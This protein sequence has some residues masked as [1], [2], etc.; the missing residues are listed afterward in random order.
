MIVIAQEYMEKNISQIHDKEYI[1]VTNI[2][3]NSVL[4]KKYERAMAALAICAE[5]EFQWNQYY[6]NE[7]L[8]K[9]LLEIS[10]HIFTIKSKE[11]YEKEDTIVFYDGF[12]LDTRGLALIYIKALV[13]S[14]KKI[15]Y[16]TLDTA[17]GKQPVLK[18]LFNGKNIIWEYIPTNFTYVKSARTLYEVINNY[19]PKAAFLYTTPYD[20]IGLSVFNYLKNRT[21]RYQINLTDH[22]FWLG[23][24]AFDYCIEFRTYGANISS[25]YRKI[26]KNKIILLP[27]YPYVDKKIKYEGLPFECEGKKILFSGGSLYKTIS[28]DNIYY[29]IID[30]ILN[31]TKEVIF[32][33][34]GTGDATYLDRLIDK[35]PN[36]VYHIQERTDLFQLMQ[37]I[38]IY[39]NTYPMIGGLMTQYAAVAGKL[40][41]MLKH[42]NDG[43]GIL[44]EQ[45][46]CEIEY[47]EWKS[48]VDDIICLLK[49]DEYLKEREEKI[50]DSV[51]SEDEFH[52]QLMEIIE[53]HKTKYKINY[54]VIDTDDFRKEYIGRFSR[55]KMSRI[56]FKKKNWCL[57]SEYKCCF[58]KELVKRIRK[59]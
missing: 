31:G 39:L 58:F 6:C 24:N 11:T 38:T 43:D 4:Q 7:K 8:E 48:I 44:I 34:A 57:W 41:L 3:E 25:Y 10:S 28:K 45:E 54:E 12:G 56:I 37:H 13:E 49:N 15:V 46:K 26:D 27:Y 14:E 52:H 32:L 51:I 36:R 30:E 1:K 47:D 18:Q 35:Y 50:K 22:A 17:K 40:P 5:I 59:I 21:T 33:F 42:G 53:K 29:K 55:E 2:I 9:Y 20:V 16:I 23:K 19:K